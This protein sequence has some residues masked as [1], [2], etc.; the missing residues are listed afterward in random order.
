MFASAPPRA[1]ADDGSDHLF[2]ELDQ[3]ILSGMQ[4]FAIP[5]VAV[6]I[7]HQGKE[8]VRG[9][10]VTDVGNPQPVDANTVFRIA[11]TSKTFT[12]TTAMRLADAGQLELD[13]EVRRYITR[14]Q[15]PKGAG[16]VTV[17]PVAEPLGRLAR[18]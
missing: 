15:P 3:K 18:L 14:F 9:Y 8:Y 13:A 2:R 5:G 12:G 4:A 10:G 1:H 6:G 7:I 16:G 11:S 17:A